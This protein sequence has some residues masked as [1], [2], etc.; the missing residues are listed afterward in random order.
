VSEVWCSEGRSPLFT[1]PPNSSPI[2]LS[3]A[4]QIANPSRIYIA[5]PSRIYKD[6]REALVPANGL[7]NRLRREAVANLPRVATSNRFGPTGCHW[8]SSA[9]GWT[10]VDKPELERTSTDDRKRF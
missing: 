6:A 9:E 8:L 5:N 7:E 4:I 3:A 2:A 1:N 10:S